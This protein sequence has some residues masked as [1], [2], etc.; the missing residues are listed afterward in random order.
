MS[1]VKARRNLLETGLDRQISY[2]GW[3]VAKRRLGHWL[4]RQGL[5]S[6]IV[7]IMD[8]EHEKKYET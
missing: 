2:A 5:N 6:F 4:S 3:K 1:T 7:A 8:Y